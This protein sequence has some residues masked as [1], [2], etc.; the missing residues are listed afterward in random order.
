MR[1]KIRL[2]VAVAALAA[3][4]VPASATDYVPVLNPQTVY[5]HCGADKVSANKTASYNWNTTAPTTSFTANGGCGHIDSDKLEGDGVRWSGT[6]T[7]NLDELTARAWVIDAGPVRAGAYAEIYA[8][9]TLTVDGVP[10]MGAYEIHLTPQP[11]STGVARLLTFSI[12]GIGLLDET[13]AGQHT[14]TLDLNTST[15]ADGDQVGWVLDAS[16]VDSGI[17]FSPPTLERSIIV[18]GEEM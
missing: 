18:L 9:V 1:T 5:V 6:H 13:E 15:Y 4:A 14:I 12:D 7:G 17:K 10:L 11:S 2:L 16:E 8:D 3:A